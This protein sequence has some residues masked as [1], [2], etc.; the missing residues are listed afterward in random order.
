MEKIVIK[1]GNRLSGEVSISGAKNAVAAI[2]PATILAE[3][4]CVIENVPDIYDVTTLLSILSEMG[5]EIR[6]I[7]RSSISINTTRIS[8]PVVPYHLA[9]QLRASYYFLGVLLAKFNHAEV[10]FPGGCNF[11]TRPIDQHFKGFRCLGAQDSIDQGGMINVHAETLTG[12]RVYLDMA[13]VGATIN[14][15]LAA[16][17]AQ[18]LT[19]IE[20]AA[21]EPHIVDLA[22]FL[23]SIGAQI[24][25]AGT[26]VIK[27]HGVERFTGA[28]YS[29]IPDQI[30]CGTYMVAAASTRG[31]VLLKNIIPKHMEPI[32]SKLQR[33][34]V[35]VQEFDD[36]IR[37][38]VS[39]VLEKNN[40][41]T[42]PYPGFPTDMQPQMTA[43]MTCAE[44]TSIMAENVWDNRFQYVDE[45]R[46]MGAKISVDGKVAVVEGGELTGAPV[47]A[48]DLRA[49]AAMVIA[50]L[51]A[52]GVTEIENINYIERGY[53]NMIQK[54]TK[55]G[56]DI[57]K[58]YVPEQEI[59]RAL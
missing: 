24:M 20:N 30:E 43:L 23:N 55:L 25:G 17:K 40:I 36:S 52:K 42:M 5:A 13:S 50:G 10:S 54:L 16:V 58:T 56:A 53:E 45:L 46:R 1:G 6:M 2:L 22:N 57:R 59:K 11:G 48:T 3:E 39:G 32:T 44:G 27:I 4:T 12:S 21:K 26:D 38:R 8:R 35:D 51:A 47:C 28:T 18:G 9:K 19:V 15:M 33:M 14:I 49:G 37:I 29:V 31:D 41:K 34:G 7:N